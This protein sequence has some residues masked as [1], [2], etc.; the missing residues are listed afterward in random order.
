V[1]ASLAMAGSADSWDSRWVGRAG[2]AGS[3]FVEHAIVGETAAV[4]TI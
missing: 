3:E 1:V 2:L 4:E